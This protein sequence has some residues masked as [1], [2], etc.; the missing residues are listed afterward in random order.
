[1]NQVLPCAS[2]PL[3]AP[4]L[5]I[6]QTSWWQRLTRGARRLASPRA[7]WCDFVGAQWPDLIMQADVTDDF[8]S[9]QG[10]TTAR[11]PLEAGA[12]LRQQTRQKGMCSVCGINVTAIRTN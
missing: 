11:W 12:N 6:G 8:H 3:S 7:D 2:Q 1:M 4:S 10:R 9:K 5:E